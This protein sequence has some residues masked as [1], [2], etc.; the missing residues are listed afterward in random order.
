MTSGGVYRMIKSFDVHFQLNGFISIE[1]ESVD[2]AEKIFLEVYDG[3]NKILLI[4]Y[5]DLDVTDVIE[6]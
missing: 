2:E 6:Y 1:A 5:A 4:D 3:K